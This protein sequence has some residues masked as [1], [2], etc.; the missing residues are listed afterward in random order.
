MCTMIAGTSPLSGSAKGP[1]GWFS[2]EQAYVG[3]DHPVHAPLD[4]ALSIDFVNEQ[5]GVGAR[6]AVELTRD[7]ARDLA[8]RIL[9]AVDAAERYEADDPGVERR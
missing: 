1:Q 9:E 2:I 7:S 5:Q 6:V 8:H 3:Y 4:H